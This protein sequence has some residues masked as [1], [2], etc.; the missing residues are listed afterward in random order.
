[1]DDIKVL[2]TSIYSIYANFPECAGK[3]DEIWKLMRHID[4]DFTCN[5]VDTYLD[6]DCHAPCK[7]LKFS[8]ALKVE[9]VGPS[10]PVSIM[11]EMATAF[12]RKK[13]PILPSL[14]RRVLTVGFINVLMLIVDYDLVATVDIQVE[15]ESVLSKHVTE[16]LN[17]LINTVVAL[18]RGASSWR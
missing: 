12:G 18:Q 14:A 1:M 16:Y 3:V 11:D 7:T 17:E 5:V 8:M 4:A 6:E 10:F 9:E 13:E 2:P 15:D